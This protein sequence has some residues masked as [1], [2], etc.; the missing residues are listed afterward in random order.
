MVISRVIYTKGLK[1]SDNKAKMA[2]V[3]FG[4]LLLLLLFFFMSS[5]VPAFNV[6][7]CQMTINF[8]FQLIIDY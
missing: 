2:D 7:V 4:V 8:E 1:K 6:R 5:D 3:M